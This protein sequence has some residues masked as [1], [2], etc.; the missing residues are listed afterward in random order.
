MDHPLY[1]VFLKLGG[2]K[3]V[4]VGGGSVATA[5]LDALLEAGARV[6][7]VAPNISG[8]ME[9]SGVT[10]VKRPFEDS[11]VDGAWWV[12][13]AAT[14]DVNAQ[15]ALVLER[16]QH[17]INAVDDPRVATAYTGGVLRRDGVTVALSTNGQCP[18]LAGLL[19]EALEAL[20]PSDV[21]Q[22]VLAARKA[23]DEWKQ[24]GVPMVQRRP[25]LL[26]VL[27]R[28]YGHAGG[29]S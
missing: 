20:I 22:W 3:V 8:R 6:T 5:K 21:A 27:N 11:D 1:P 23:R 16:K 29:A 28:L 12:V 18:A 7:V 24:Q 14:P 25:L 17:F 26:N 2:R 19:R 13:A 4:L 9:R 15:V 10:L